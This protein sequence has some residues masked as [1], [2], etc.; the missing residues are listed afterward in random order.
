MT[1]TSTGSA[2]LYWLAPTKNTNGTALNNLAGV[3]IY[4]G[5]SASNLSHV[6]QVPSPETAYTIGNLAAGV[7]Y[8][9]AAAYTT[10]GMQGTRSSVASKTIP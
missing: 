1:S 9:A 4:Y 6:V 10:T 7:W 5:T 8:F 3:R 2:R